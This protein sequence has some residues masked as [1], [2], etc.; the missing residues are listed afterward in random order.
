MVSPWCLAWG[1]RE[2]M[3]VPPQ[4]CELRCPWVSLHGCHTYICILVL[5]DPVEVEGPAID[6]ELGAGDVHGADADRE[7]VH[8]L[9]QHPT[10]L[11][12]HLHLHGQG[13]WRDPHWGAQCSLPCLGER[14]WPH[15]PPQPCLSTQPA[16]HCCCSRG[17]ARA[18]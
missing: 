13:E 4:Q 14:F 18:D 7:R 2:R 15:I 12:L 10:H 3:Q 11:G 6:E 1:E 5:V 8:V 17:G 9:Q 16:P